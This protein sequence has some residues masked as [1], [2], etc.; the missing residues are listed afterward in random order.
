MNMKTIEGMSGEKTKEIKIHRMDD[1][2]FAELGKNYS[3][4]AYNCD[5]DKTCIWFS[6]EWCEQEVTIWPLTHGAF[7]ALMDDIIDKGSEEE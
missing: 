7:T 1:E 6:F 4:G 5:E 2:E 3:T